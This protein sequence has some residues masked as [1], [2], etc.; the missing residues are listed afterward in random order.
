MTGERGYG[1]CD[2]ML[3]IMQHDAVLKPLVE[4]KSKKGVNRKVCSSNCDGEIR[5]F[6]CPTSLD[7]ELRGT[8]VDTAHFILWAGGW[9]TFESVKLR[10]LGQYCIEY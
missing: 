3:T 2:L 4:R 8:G 7:E 1:R 5:I 9:G 6:Y 10:T